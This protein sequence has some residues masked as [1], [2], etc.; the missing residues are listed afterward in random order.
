[1]PTAPHRAFSIPRHTGLNNASFRREWW[2]TA[3]HPELKTEL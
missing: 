1:L 3:R 2:V